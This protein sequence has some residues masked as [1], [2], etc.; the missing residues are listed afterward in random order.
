MIRVVKGLCPVREHREPFKP[1]GLRGRARLSRRHDF[2]R[3]PW[4]RRSQ[5]PP[6]RSSR[7]TNA[8]S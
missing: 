2:L 1:S 7:R 8:G 6:F 3:H 4:S 5:T